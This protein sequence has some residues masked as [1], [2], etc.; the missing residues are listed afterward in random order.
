MTAYIFL[1]ALMS[2]SASASLILDYQGLNF[3]T[4][5]T[6]TWTSGDPYQVF[7]PT[8]NISGFIELSSKLNSNATPSDISGLIVDFYFTDGVNIFDTSNATLSTFEVAATNVAGLPVDWN[9]YI[10]VDSALTNLKK[11]GLLTTASAGNGFDQGYDTLCDSRTYDYGRCTTGAHESHNQSGRVEYQ[12]SP[13]QWSYR[14]ATVPEPSTLAIF[15]L[16]MIGLASRRFKKQ[17]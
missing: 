5:T 6:T 8:D 13:E 17:S 10:E 4:F 16:G 15:A 14:A 11:S 9:I 3:E 2:T 7:Q 1:T 12:S